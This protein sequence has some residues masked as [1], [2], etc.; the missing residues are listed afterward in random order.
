MKIKYLVVILGIIALVLFSGCVPGNNGLNGVP[1]GP[2]PA[3]PQGLQGEPGLQ[4]PQGIQGI[5]GI[6]GEKGERGQ[7]DYRAGWAAINRN[8][9]LTSITFS[10]KMPSPFYAV[11]IA[12]PMGYI[13][14]YKTTMGFTVEF[15][16]PTSEQLSF[17]WIA[18][19]YN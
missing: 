18:I 13:I 4:G 12:V 8:T 3:G 14:K 2:G 1:G 11:I 9:N 10:E 15:L 19:P 6:P 5:Q 17:D 7:T 16:S